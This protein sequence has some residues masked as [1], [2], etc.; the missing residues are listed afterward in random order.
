MRYVSCQSSVRVSMLHK[1]P[2]IQDRGLGVGGLPMRTTTSYHG[3]VHISRAALLINDSFYV[4]LRLISAYREKSLLH[5][6]FVTGLEEPL[7]PALISHQ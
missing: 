7:G 4:L 3:S 6:S 5:N 1:V 2:S